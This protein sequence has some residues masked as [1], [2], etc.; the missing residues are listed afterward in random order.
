MTRLT[1]LMCT[2]LLLGNFRSHLELQSRIF[3]DDLWKKSARSVG[4]MGNED[5]GSDERLCDR[6]RLICCGR[7]LHAWDIASQM[8]TVLRPVLAVLSRQGVGT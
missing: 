1:V 2:R 7:V 5:L 8:P 4:H 3:D 6:L